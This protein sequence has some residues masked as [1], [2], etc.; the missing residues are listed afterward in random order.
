MERA[1]GFAVPI[2][3]VRQHRGLIA[4]VWLAVAGC[5]EL[6][7]RPLE[8]AGDSPT[9]TAAKKNAAQS[10]ATSAP[11]P[12]DRDGFNAVS[13]PNPPSDGY[14]WRDRQLEALVDVPADERPDLLAALTGN[15]PQA[16]L[17]AAIL[18]ARAGDGR[19]R[20]RLLEAIR[21]RKARLPQ[22]CAAAEALALLKEPSPVAELC[23]LIDRFGQFS[24]A[25]YQPGLHAELLYGLAPLVDACAEPR[26][27]A[28]V[29][30]PS[31]EVRLAAARGC[32]RPAAGKLPEVIADLRTDGDA[33]VR[34][35]ALAAMA[36]HRHPFTMEA[37]RGAL[38]DFR[39]EVRLAA[40]SALGEIGGEEARQTLARLEREPEVIRAAAILALA[41]LGDRDRVWTAAESPSWHVRKAAATALRA[42]PDRGGTLLA[43]RLLTDASLEVEK[44]VLE[45]LAVWPLETS[46]PVLL[47]ALGGDGYLSRKTAAAQL[48]GRWP[49][50]ADFSADA[51][52]ER[53]AEALV[54]LRAQ[55][56]R[57]YGAAALADAAADA[58]K[59]ADALPPID[60]QTT[61]RVADLVRRLGTSPAGDDATALQEL[62]ACG[63]PLPRILEQLVEQ[64]HLVL[65][66]IVYN[67]VLPA[68][69][70]AF[71]ALESLSSDDVLKRR[72]AANRLAALAAQSPLS[73]LAL[74]RLSEL[75]AAEPDTLVF[76]GLARAIG[77]DAREPAVRLAYAG[78]SH[79]D[80]EVRRVSAEYLAAHPAP[81]HARLLVAALSDSQYAVVLAVVKALGHPGMLDDPAPLEQ[82]L[83]TTDRPLR[84]AVA[85]S[86]AVLGAP[87]GAQTLELLAR[88][89]DA[90]TRQKAAQLMGE[91]ADRRYAETLIG[92]L[93][94][95][96]LGV[97]TA[98]LAALAEV[99]G[100]DVADAPD[101]PPQS[102]LD[103]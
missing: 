88:D 76:S 87:S 51:P 3:A 100:R 62:K 71:A 18:L 54:K 70:P 52:A 89:T 9:P 68:Y 60:E 59:T 24:S 10:T 94:D 75:G 36:A 80:A 15:R 37:A 46:G 40:I 58:R 30:S 85:N 99:A 61:R 64:E 2:A 25:A 32:A 11:L 31:P 34:A 22:R 8:R 44:E 27:A 67:E 79:R 41:K 6:H 19:G 95:R 48:A 90:D 45:T 28:A 13:A 53:R 82:L 92:L 55:W 56:A 20:A 14:R 29:K 98:A 43:R 65:P 4:L 97:R 23:E 66:D 73:D 96:T 86:L 42:W 63:P 38:G 12:L 83:T 78:L 74:A 69:G 102:T 101:D 1:K 16:S 57:Q 93:D 26:F 7:L 47:E 81:Q 91:R 77:G 72:R 49:A 5:N 33:R 35:A 50:A 84:L 21:D 17:N 39:L 103:R